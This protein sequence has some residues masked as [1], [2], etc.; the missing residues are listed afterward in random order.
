MELQTTARGRQ[1]ILAISKQE[2]IENQEDLEAV[3]LP[4]TES[5]QA[6]D[7]KTGTT[8]T[9][10]DLDDRLNFPTPDR[11]KELLIY[12]YGRED[13]FKVFVNGDSLS[14]DDVPGKT[15]KSEANLSAAG[16]AALHFTI[17]E[18]K[19]TPKSPGI[20]LKVNGKAVGKPHYFG[21]DEDEDIPEKLLKKVYGEVELTGVEDYVTADW[22]AVIENSKAYVETR[23][24]IK[25]EVKKELRETHTRDM[26][27][28][29]AR[30]QKAIQQRL[31]KLP[32]HRR[33]FAEEAL[34]R[35]L[36]RFYGEA[37]D[38]VTA[39][40]EVALDAMEHDAYWAVLESINTS[41]ERDVSTFADSLE[42]F[43][44]VEL[45]SVGV[46][47]S[48]RSKFLDFL[49]QLIRNP[50]TLEKEAHKA[51]ETNLWMLGRQYSLMASNVTLRTI[52]GTYCD[53]KFSGSRSS[54]RPDLLHRTS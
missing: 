52:V 44:L 12:E 7:A 47:A 15:I 21:L 38:R 2:L 6:G 48:H 51:F 8:I 11:L 27:L 35:I 17:A 13:G 3:P 46:Q 37:D 40:A 4:F 54:K 43:G 14:V 16:S 53:S 49:E 29:K 5:D 26:N 22:G 24:F 10:S 42:Q 32:E 23:E 30:L 28:Q 20:I 25:N 33:K 45:A 19:R 36:R 31:Q 18:G 39:I 50:A 41:S 9:L 34:N 1:C